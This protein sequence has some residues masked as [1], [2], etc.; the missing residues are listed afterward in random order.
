MKRKEKKKWNKEGK[1]ESRG[2]RERNKERRDNGGGAGVACALF[3]LFGASFFS[4]RISSRLFV[5]PKPEEAPHISKHISFLLSIPGMLPWRFPKT[6]LHSSGASGSRTLRGGPLVERREKKVRAGLEVEGA[7]GR[8]H[9]SST[10]GVP[11][12]PLPRNRNPTFD[13]L[14][15]RHWKSCPVSQ[16][17]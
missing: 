1:G 6:N 7:Q 8:N 10:T 14:A 11:P 5:S 13:W 2:K 9:V 12:T 16:F 3:A 15:S 4:S 17:S